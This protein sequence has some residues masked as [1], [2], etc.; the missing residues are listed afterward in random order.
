MGARDGPVKAGTGQTIAPSAQTHI[1]EEIRM[2]TKTVTIRRCDENDPYELYWAVDEREQDCMIE[3]D[4]ETGQLDAS[5]NTEIGNAVPSRVWHGVVRRYPL[6]CLSS[7]GANRAM[8]AIRILAQRVLDGSDV[9]WDG[10]NWVGIINDDADT[11]EWAIQK[12]LQPE[13]FSDSDF[14]AVWE[15]SEFFGWHGENL[16]DSVTFSGEETEKEL[17][18]LCDILRKEFTI[19]EST[20]SPMV[21]T[22]LYNY[23]DS[24]RELVADA[25]DDGYEWMRDLVI[26]DEEEGRE[27]DPQMGWSEFTQMLV[28]ANDPAFPSYDS[29]RENEAAELGAYAYLISRR[30]E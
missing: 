21:I 6:P 12:E 16:P 7:Q 10:S 9:V 2:T 23:L 18:D 3:L 27:V 20:G 17:M 22:G 26:R 15:A 24:I 1:K 19:D 8:E 29:D 5:Y 4:L 28:N 14:V 11:A 25:S 30:E 13:N